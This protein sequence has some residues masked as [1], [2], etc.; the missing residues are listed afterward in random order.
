MTITGLTFR[1]E[2]SSPLTVAEADGNI[3]KL[4]DAIEGL[5]LEDVLRVLSVASAF[6]NIII[7]RKKMVGSVE[8][9]R[10]SIGLGDGT[11]TINGGGG[12][13]NINDTVADFNVPVQ[14]PEGT[15]DFHALRKDQV[16]ALISEL[17]LSNILAVSNETLYDIKVKNAVLQSQ[18]TSGTI[19]ALLSAGALQ[20]K[21]LAG[22]A[23][24]RLQASNVLSNQT[25]ELPSAPGT[26]ALKSQHS[27]ILKNSIA[28]SGPYSTTSLTVL[29]YFYIPAGTINMGSLIVKNKIDKNGT[30]GSLELKIW[31]NSSS[32]AA[33]TQVAREIMGSTIQLAPFDREFTIAAGKVLKCFPS[34]VSQ[35]N[36]KVQSTARFESTTFDWDVDNYIVISAAAG[37]ASDAYSL[38]ESSLIY[39]PSV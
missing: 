28:V 15:A 11:A 34:T 9:E 24:A 27:L 16:V 33:G 7:T 30:A 13:M 18:N 38:F 25:Y 14:I 32:A 35:V 4:R 26:L 6:T 20:I 12:Q 31:K 36:D 22:S 17:G 1:S 21:T 19:Y 10:A 5:T 3:D 8:T 39:I 29:A 23:I 2:K 37:S